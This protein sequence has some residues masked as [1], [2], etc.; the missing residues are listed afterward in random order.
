MKE[1]VR[2]LLNSLDII[3]G[4]PDKLVNDVKLE[5]YYKNLEINRGSLLSSYL[6][7]SKFQNAKDKSQFN[8]YFWTELIELVTKANATYFPYLE[9]VGT[10]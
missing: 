5:N 4:Y 8:Y 1:N 10:E 9:A 3:V 6:N 7:V 2:H